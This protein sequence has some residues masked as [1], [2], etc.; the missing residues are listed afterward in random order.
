MQVSEV[1]NLRLRE[2]SAGGQTLKPCQVWLCD[3]LLCFLGAGVSEWSTKAKA[4][5]IS[6]LIYFWERW[7]PSP[8][9][10]SSCLC[11]PRDHPELSAPQPVSSA[12][13]PPSS[14]HRPPECQLYALR[15]HGLDWPVFIRCYGNTE[16]TFLPAPY[17]GM[18][19][20]P[21]RFIV[22]SPDLQYDYIWR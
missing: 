17:F 14:V 21:L 4:A 12:F 16:Q 7:A 11:G 22:W 18:K 3:P 19:C 8:T 1:G 6:L 13:A 9:W 5:Q 15:H 2:K 20:F 10:Y